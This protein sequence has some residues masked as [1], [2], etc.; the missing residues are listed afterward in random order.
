MFR[1]IVVPMVAA[2]VLTTLVGV[3]AASAAETRATSI[4]IDG[5]HCAGCAK[6]VATR[7]RAVAGVAD[8]QVNVETETAAVTPKDK[9][10]LSPRSL[11]EAIEAAG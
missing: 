7:L 9:T 6:K 5:M 4:A 2:F 8:A 3:Q 10:V 11:W 1:T